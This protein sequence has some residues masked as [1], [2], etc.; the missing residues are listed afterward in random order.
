MPTY[1]FSILFAGLKHPREAAALGAVWVVGR[2]AYA[3]GYGTGDPQGRVKG[4][5]PS[6]LALMALLGTATYTAIE[7]IQEAGG[8]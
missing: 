8:F 4:A 7:F 1:L 5:I 2:T 3:L 6:G